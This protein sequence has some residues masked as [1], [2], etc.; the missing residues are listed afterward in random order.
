MSINF[1]TIFSPYILKSNG[2]Q[3][4]LQ[5][6]TTT[7]SLTTVN[8]D[9]MI[10]IISSRN[11]SNEGYTSAPMAGNDERPPPPTHSAFGGGDY[12]DPEGKIQSC[13]VL[14]LISVYIDIVM[15]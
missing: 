1:K 9:E 15:C 4:P 14:Y 6:T 2:H 12:H 13:F 3:H 11:G 5:P 10:D 7:T 8:D